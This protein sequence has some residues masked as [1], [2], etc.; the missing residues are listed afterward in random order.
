MKTVQWLA[1]AVVSLASLP[2]LAQQI[3]ANGQQNTSVTAGKIQANDSSR[4]NSNGSLGGGQAKASGAT[5][6]SGS[7]T[8]NHGSAATGSAATGSATTNGAAYAAGEMRPVSGELQGKLDSKTA[9]AGDPVIVK[10]T[11]KTKTA[12]GV[13][14][15]KGSRLV[16][17]VTSAQAHAKGKSESQLGIAF[18]RAEL[19]G[20]QSIAIHSMIESIAPPASAM[21]AAEADDSADAMMSAG[22]AMASGGMVGGARGGSALGGGVVNGAV[23]GAGSAAGR[24]GSGLNTAADETASAAG[25]MSSHAAQEAAGTAHTAVGTT[26]SL[27]AHASAVPGVMLSGDAA[28]SASGMLTATGRNVE[29]QSGTQMVLGV[30]TA[31]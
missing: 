27:A 24:M 14:I 23:D 22:P 26:G 18:E 6:N 4:A 29:L 1:V 13:E 21:A 15:P 7:V 16:G 8:G 31:K 28:G 10:T 3:D 9:K 20:G 5:A 2:L 17:H 12:D 11:Q 25:R 30:S 19:K